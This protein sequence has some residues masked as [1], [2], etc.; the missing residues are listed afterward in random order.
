M[1][2]AAAHHIAVRTRD[3]AALAAF[4]TTNL[5][6]SEL[7][8]FRDDRGLRSVWL[9]LGTTIVM[10]ERAEQQERRAADADEGYF[11]VAFS[12]A[13]GERDAWQKR[14]A[15]SG[16]PMTHA[17]DYSLYFRDPDGNRFALSHYPELA[18]P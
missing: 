17:S 6:L 7:R 5:G 13:S 11:L 12:I 14:L 16:C 2:I 15:D 1:K 9:E 4:Y 3:V 18:E 10:I 8:E